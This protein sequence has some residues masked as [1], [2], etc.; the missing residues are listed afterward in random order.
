L[1]QSLDV[2]ADARLRKAELA[3]GFGKASHFGDR[4][5]C[6]QVKWIEHD[7]FASSENPITDI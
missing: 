5:E 2:F 4:E 6:A 7:L 3:P 1:L